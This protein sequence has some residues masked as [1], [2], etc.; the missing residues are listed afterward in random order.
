[1]QSYHDFS[2]SRYKHWN[3]SQSSVRR[4]KGKDEI[5]TSE[6]RVGTFEVAND[7]HQ[8]TNKSSET[9]YDIVDND[10]DSPEAVKRRQKKR[11][12]EEVLSSEKL[13]L[14]ALKDLAISSGGLV[15]GRDILH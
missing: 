1:M 3:N 7:I 5:N 14:E 9:S 8:D 12:I 13:D 6:Q 2:L 4:R 10:D 11:K 15:D